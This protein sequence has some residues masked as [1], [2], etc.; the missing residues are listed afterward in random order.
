MRGTLA[1]SWGPWGGV[2]LHRR[3]ICLGWL[4]IT[5]VPSVEIDD[6][7]EAYVDRDLSRWKADA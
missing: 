3:R 1:I 2:Y 7:M 5:F 6:L 4:A